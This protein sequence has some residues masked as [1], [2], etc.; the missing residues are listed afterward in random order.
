MSTDNRF[1]TNCVE[2]S[3]CTLTYRVVNVVTWDMTHTPV[4]SDSS[5]RHIGCF[6]YRELARRVDSFV[7]RRTSEINAR[8]LPPLTNYVVFCRP[9]DLQVKLYCWLRTALL[10]PV[11]S[12]VTAASGSVAAW[13]KLSHCLFTAMLLLFHAL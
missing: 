12:S 3:V 1:Y 2:W 11:Y 4:Q 6:V 9:T 10:L 5:G 8:Y 7:L 13:V